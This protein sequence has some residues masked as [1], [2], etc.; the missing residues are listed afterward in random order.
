MAYNF[1]RGDLRPEEAT[2]AR[3]CAPDPDLAR[4]GARPA[5]LRGAAASPYK[6]APA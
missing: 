6:T 2:P 4:H 3:P 1:L 5:G